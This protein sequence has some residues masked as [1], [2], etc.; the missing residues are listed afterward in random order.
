M[1]S[2]RSSSW[3]MRKMSPDS[4]GSSPEVRRK[5]P[6]RLC[7]SRT[8]TPVGSDRQLGVTRRQIRVGVEQGRLAAADQVLAVVQRVRAALGAVGADQDEV[9]ARRGSSGRRGR[10]GP[11]N[12]VRGLAAARRRLARRA[13]ASCG[14]RTRRRRRTRPAHGC[15]RSGTRRRPTPLRAP[16]PGAGWRDAHHDRRRRR[17]GSA[18]RR[19]TDGAA[20]WTRR[21]AP[22]GAGP[23][24]PARRAAAP[25]R[26]RR[27]LRRVVP[28]DSAARAGSLAPRCWSSPAAAV[29]AH[30][31]RRTDPRR[32]GPGR[33]QAA[34]CRAVSNASSG[35]AARGRRH[36]AP[37][38]ALEISLPQPRQNL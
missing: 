23:A 17:Q 28:G 24:G 34:R 5:T 13:P 16:L 14:C 20:G 6:L 36:R 8:V 32:L 18:L 35:A 25:R 15:R 37:G 38:R 10:S 4:S 3:P 19:A 2:K 9:A 26:D 1:T 7:R 11:M 22:A 33:R 29:I 27:H 12:I 30:A 21:C 31:D